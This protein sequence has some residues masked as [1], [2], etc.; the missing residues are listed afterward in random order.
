MSVVVN[1]EDDEED[2]EM[3]A[4]RSKNNKNVF[5]S[6]YQCYFDNILGIK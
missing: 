5:K 6:F 3:G 2:I 1:K 4:D